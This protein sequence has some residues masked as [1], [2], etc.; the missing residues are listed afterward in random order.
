M[1]T[2]RSCKQEKDLDSFGFDKAQQDG[3]SKSCKVCRA[4]YQRSR[5]S[6]YTPEQKRVI[7]ERRRKVLRRNQDLLREYLLNHPCLDCG[8]T[9][10]RVLEFDHLRDKKMGITWALR[11]MYSWEDILREIEKCEVVCANCHK[12]RTYSRMKTW[13]TNT[14]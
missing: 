3:K 10:I 5:Y 2:C 6:Q 7:Y 1:K 12:I 8:T 4:T 9:D 14:L 11:F 13:R